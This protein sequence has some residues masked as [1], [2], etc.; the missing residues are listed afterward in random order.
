[1]IRARLPA[2]VSRA[3]VLFVGLTIL[4]GMAA[5]ATSNAEESDTPAVAST[6]G[7]EGYPGMPALTVVP[8]LEEIRFFP[9]QNCHKFLAGDTQV[10]ELSSPHTNELEHG[11][12]RI[13]CMNCHA[14]EDRDYLVTALGEPVEYDE[15]HLVCGG[16]HGNRHKDWYFGAHGKR[17][18]NWQGER[19]VYSC[20]HCHDPHAPAL[21]PRAP[22][23]PPPVRA[24]LERPA[25]EDHEPAMP[26]E[27]RGETE[28]R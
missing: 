22:E 17:A 8:R 20:A 10:R 6:P 24:G 23:A 25:G 21:E 13:W 9:C 28:Q 1:M 4:L 15:S 27:T 3:R 14:R 12:G 18:G 2:G 7:F 19:R 11:A 16:C 26:W 5:A